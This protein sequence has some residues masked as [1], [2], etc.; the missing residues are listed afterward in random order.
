[1]T[2]ILYTVG[3]IVAIVVLGCV[4][5]FVE[6]CFTKRKNKR[7]KKLFGKNVRKFDKGG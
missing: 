4:V 6:Y 5:P 3:I 2:N 1:M 7:Y